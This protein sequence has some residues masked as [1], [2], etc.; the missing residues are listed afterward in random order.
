MWHAKL[1]FFQDELSTPLEKKSG[2]HSHHNCNRKDCNVGRHSKKSRHGMGSL[3]PSLPKIN[4]VDLSKIHRYIFE[5]QIS[6]QFKS[7]IRDPEY[8]WGVFF[9]NRWVCWRVWFNKNILRNKNMKM[10]M[11]TTLVDSGGGSGGGGLGGGS[12][13]Y[14]PLLITSTDDLVLPI[15]AEVNWK[16]VTALIQISGMGPR[17]QIL[18]SIKTVVFQT[19]T[20]SR[21][22]SVALDNFL[23]PICGTPVCVIVCL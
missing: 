3:I 15:N 14:L 5:L 17:L 9:N 16:V 11:Q 13:D 20:Q 22:V 12:D 18:G 10:C 4:F 7:R 2:G 19:K 8:V 23:G 1:D 21:F 6:F